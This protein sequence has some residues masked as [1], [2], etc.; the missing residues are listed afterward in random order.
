MGE[1]CP[2]HP[3]LGALWFAGGSFSQGLRSRYLHSEGVLLEASA[4][5]LPKSFCQPLL[6]GGPHLCTFPHSDSVLSTCP[7]L[8][9]SSSPRKHE[10]ATVFCSR[11]LKCETLTSVFVCLILQGCAA[12]R[13]QMELGSRGSVL[14]PDL[15]ACYTFVVCD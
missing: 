9:L 10:P 5:T 15:A 3:R 4:G 14:S 2:P 12:L 8:T 13:G 1:S 11:S 6:T 7:P